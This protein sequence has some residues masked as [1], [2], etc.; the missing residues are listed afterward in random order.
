MSL[1]MDDGTPWYPGMHQPCRDIYNLLLLPHSLWVKN[2]DVRLLLTYVVPFVPIPASLPQVS[3]LRPLLWATT[4]KQ[5]GHPAC[6][7][8][9]QQW[10][11]GYHQ[12]RPGGPHLGLHLQGRMDTHQHWRTQVR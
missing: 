6:L 1:D 2:A 5:E 9:Q 3:L 12:A 10:A 11:A 7:R 4:C 8:Q